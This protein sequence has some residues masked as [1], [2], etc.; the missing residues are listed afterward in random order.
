[1]KKRIPI[2]SGL[3][4]VLAACVLIGVLAATRATEQ[5]VAEPAGLDGTAWALVSWTHPGELPVVPISLQIEA[6]SL[7]GSSGCNNYVGPVTMDETGFSAG[8]MATTMMY[9]PNSAE[10]EDTYLGLLAT[11]DGWTMDG[12]HLVLTAG[13]AETLRFAAA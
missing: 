1:V 6:G 3:A 8:P 5:A 4:G 10:A 2:I 9:C 12:D 13:G 7:H 11:V